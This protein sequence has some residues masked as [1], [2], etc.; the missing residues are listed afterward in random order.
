MCGGTDRFTVKHTSGGDRWHCRQC[1]D[2][3]YHGVVDLIMARDHVSF[4]DA[5]KLLGG[6]VVPLC[7]GTTKGQPQAQ[8]TR[9]IE[10]PDTATQAAMLAA[11]DAANDR[12]FTSAGAAAQEYLRSR[13]L[14]VST[15][16][17]WHI[18]AADVYDPKA[19]R[20]RPALALPWYDLDA[21]REIITAIKYRFIDNDPA[22]LRYIS[23]K[24]SAPI[25]YGAAAAINT[26]KTLLIIEG[27]INALSVWQCQPHGVSVLSIGSEG[28]GPG[29]LLAKIAK[30][31]QR[32]FIW[33]DEAS[34][35]NKHKKESARPDAKGLQTPIIDGVKLDANKLLQRGQL[36]DFI[37]KMIGVDC[38]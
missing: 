36:V 5:L 29:E 31:Y 28:G 6:E 22:G 11:M 1:G 37:N 4:T 8:P 24:G 18:G 7:R 19:K 15:W 21:R 30:Y 38:Q 14:T 32:V 27:E 3:K 23:F 26:D 2:G 35:T 20:T 33:C 12:L 9:V 34:Q 16:E 10:P 25:I 17:A 13:A